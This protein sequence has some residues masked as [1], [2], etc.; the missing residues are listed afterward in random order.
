MTLYRV[1]GVRAFRGHAP[2]AQFEARLDPLHEK[3]AV[4]R[5]DITVIDPTPVSIRPGSYALPA[6]WLNPTKEN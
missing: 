6:G 2:G 1:S 3:R 4:A 5:G